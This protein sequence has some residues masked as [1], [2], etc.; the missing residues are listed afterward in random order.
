MAAVTWG[1][2]EAVENKAART[3][4]VSLDSFSNT[5]HDQIPWELLTGGALPS[6]LSDSPV[7]GSKILVRKF[8]EFEK[9]EFEKNFHHR[10]QI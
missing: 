4:S 3:A 8:C 5:V 2:G 6:E 1:H 10:K 7:C 9:F